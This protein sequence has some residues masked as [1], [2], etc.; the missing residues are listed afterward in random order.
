MCISEGVSVK[1]FPPA[2]SSSSWVL[3][4]VAP[5]SARPGSAA[6]PGA[7]AACTQ[8][9]RPVQHQLA[10]AW[11]WDAAQLWRVAGYGAQRRLLS[12][13]C[14]AEVRYYAVISKPT[15]SE[16]V[17]CY[18]SAGQKQGTHSPTVQHSCNAGLSTNGGAFSAVSVM[19]LM[20]CLFFGRCSS[21][22]ALLTTCG[23]QRYA[24]R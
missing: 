5:G 6:P 14:R 24:R 23:R 15:S 3:L 7:R 4:M 10:P 13:T 2:T 18:S 1:A 9:A 19:K 22:C 11:G 16:Y 17:V 8:P 21:P 20:A 12:H